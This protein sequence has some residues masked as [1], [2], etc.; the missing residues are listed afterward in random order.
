[1]P[2]QKLLFPPTPVGID[3]D[4][5][6]LDCAPSRRALAAWGGLDLAE[7]CHDPEF[8]RVLVTYGRIPVAVVSVLISDETA[9]ATMQGVIADA[10]HSVRRKKRA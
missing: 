7:A 2:Y 4:K 3:V 10:A 1:M 6:P 9:R 5:L 8:L